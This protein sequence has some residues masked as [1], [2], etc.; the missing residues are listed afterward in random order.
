M[1]VG[2]KQPNGSYLGHWYEVQGT[3]KGDR[4]PNVIVTPTDSSKYTF[5]NFHGEFH[6]VGAEADFSTFFRT[7]NENWIKEHP[8]YSLTGHN[9]QLY[10]QDVLQRLLNVRI[11]T[12][13]TTHG[14]GLMDLGRTI[15]NVGLG[16]LVGGL[17]S[18]ALGRHI[19]GTHL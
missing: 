10:V 7:F 17:L 18:L 16:V 13:N 3:S 15:V 4:G 6:Y 8:T 14:D 12:Q 11:E 1:F 2:I 5:V 19:K 9:C